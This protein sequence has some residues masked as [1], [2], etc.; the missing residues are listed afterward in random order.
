MKGRSTFLLIAAALV[1]VCYAGIAAAQVSLDQAS[2]DALVSAD[3]SE[4]IPPGTQI[5]MQNWQQYKNYMD[6][7]NCSPV[8]C[9]GVYPR[10]R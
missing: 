5:T 10:I 7:S 9:L 1:W 2:Y 6:C 4:T 3:S 8:S